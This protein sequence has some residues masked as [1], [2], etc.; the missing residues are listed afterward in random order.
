MQVP[1]TLVNSGKVVAPDSRPEE[2]KAHL[3]FPFERELLYGLSFCLSS[4][5]HLLRCPGASTEVL[6]MQEIRLPRAGTC[7]LRGRRS[8]DRGG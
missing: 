3:T 6:A 4:S 7:A 1:A 5:S 2:G 8:V